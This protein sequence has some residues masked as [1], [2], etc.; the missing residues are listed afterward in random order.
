MAETLPWR[1]LRSEDLKGVN[2]GTSC[3]ED[4]RG[5]VLRSLETWTYVS[6]E[7]TKYKGSNTGL[8]FQNLGGDLEL[9]S[10]EYI[11]FRYKEV[12]AL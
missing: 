11:G 10:G 12:S 5:Y 9:D 4:K 3:R 7:C 6:S 2:K 8:E 1:N